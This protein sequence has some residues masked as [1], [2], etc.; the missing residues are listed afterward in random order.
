M[1]NEY[2]KKDCNDI[3]STAINELIV[4]NKKIYQ[5]KIGDEWNNKFKG[6]RNPRD[7]MFEAFK[8]GAGTYTQQQTRFKKHNGNVT[9]ID[10]NMTFKLRLSREINE[11]GMHV[12]TDPFKNVYQHSLI[13]KNPRTQIVFSELKN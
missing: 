8:Q 4:I 5:Y 12:S 1:K 6:C 11:K 2:P 3:M 7:D 13:Y 10:M 9:I